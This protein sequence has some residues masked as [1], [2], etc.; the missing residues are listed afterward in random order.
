[1]F[2]GKPGENIFYYIY[3]N[4]QQATTT[5]EHIHEFQQENT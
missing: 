4:P 5:N 1:M 2:H 3:D